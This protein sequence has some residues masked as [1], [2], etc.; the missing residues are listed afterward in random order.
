MATWKA[1]TTG[2]F[3][4]DNGRLLCHAHLGF[5][6]KHTGY[7]ISGQRISKVTQ[8][9]KAS[10]PTFGWECEECWYANLPSSPVEA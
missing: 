10:D 4:T 3:S 1:P 6:A 5:S 7:D 2:V 8:K 9:L